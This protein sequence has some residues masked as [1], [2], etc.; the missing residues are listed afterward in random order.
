MGDK[1]RIASSQLNLTVKIRPAAVN[2]MSMATVDKAITACHCSNKRQTQS[3]LSHS[4]MRRLS[5]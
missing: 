4:C 1:Y 2:I 3:G 5:A